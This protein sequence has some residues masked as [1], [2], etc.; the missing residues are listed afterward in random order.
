MLILLLLIILIALGAQFKNVTF[1]KRIR[2]QYNNTIIIIKNILRIMIP[3]SSI[4]KKEIMIPTSSFSEAASGTASSVD[5]PLDIPL[6][7][8]EFLK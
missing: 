6:T 3:T 7:A 5:K 1:S 2:G 4:S 8:S